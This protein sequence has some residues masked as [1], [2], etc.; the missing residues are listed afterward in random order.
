MRVVSLSTSN[1]LNAVNQVAER[2]LKLAFL[3]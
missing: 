2:T 1:E 3:S